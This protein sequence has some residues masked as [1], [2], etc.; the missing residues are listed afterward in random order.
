MHPEIE[1][2]ID[3]ALADGQVTEKE[4]NVILKKATELGIDVDEAEM[5][6]DGK[7][8][9]LEAN[10]PKQKEKVGNIITCPAC[11][12]SIRSMELSCSDCGHVFTN[13]K[14]NSTVQKMFEELQ[15][16]ELSESNKTS[17]SFFD[18]LDT[19]GQKKRLDIA[20]RQSSLISSFPIP[21]SEEDLIELISMAVAESTKSTND[22]GF[23]TN[24]GSDLIKKAW[25]TKGEQALIKAKLLCRDDANTVLFLND[26]Q[27]RIDSARKSESR[28]IKP[29][30]KLLAFMIILMGFVFFISSRQL[31]RGYEN[32][33]QQKLDKVE[34][35]IN[36]AIEAKDFD[37]AM[38]LT[39]QLTWTWK[40]DYP[41]SQKKAE[42]Y[43]SKRKSLKQ[44][45]SNMQNRKSKN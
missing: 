13:V 6:L 41:E 2:L 32:E 5:V 14:A 45:I 19:S 36:A 20:T 43:N 11:G 22:D 25:I 8:H 34:Q 12:A 27:N 7:L 38:V 33:E 42:Q 44:T 29:I 17:D 31:D 28:K 9:L 30:V 3:L 40:L 16:I 18:K 39:D 35:Q 4:R 37:K 23:I 24:D 26:C 21:N 10:R 15:K 1:K